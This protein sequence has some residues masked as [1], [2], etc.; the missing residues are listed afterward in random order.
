[1]NKKRGHLQLVN[2]RFGEIIKRF[3]CQ[4]GAAVT[5]SGHFFA[6]LSCTVDQVHV[7]VNGILTM[8]SETLI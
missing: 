7:R 5:V 3:I 6:V 1:V 4:A 2:S 8:Y